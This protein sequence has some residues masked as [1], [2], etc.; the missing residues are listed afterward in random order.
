V[1]A[2]AAATVA[3]KWLL[4]PPVAPRIANYRPLTGGSHGR[5]NGLATDGE[6]AYFPTAGSLETRQ[7]AMAGGSSAPLALPFSGGY[8]VDASRARSSLLMVGFEEESAIDGPLWSVPVPAGGARKLGIEARWAAWRPDGER[9]A[10]VRSEAPSLLGVARGDGSEVTTLFESRDDLRWVRWSPDG[11]R[12]R[13]GL[14]EAGTARNWIMEIPAAGGTPRRLFPGLS[15]DWTPDGRTFLFSNGGA[16]A[17]WGWAPGAGAEGRVNLFAA[18]DPPRWQVWRKPRIEQLTTGPLHLSWPTFGKGVRRVIAWGSNWRGQLMRFDARSSRFEPL[19][20]GLQGGFLDY[21]RD[22]LWIAWVDVRD[23]TL[24][25]SRADGSEALQLTTPP[26]AVGLVRWSPDGS[27]LAFVAKPPES[28]PR[29]YVLP[30]DGGRP[31]VLSEPE[32]G[33]VWDP[34]WMPDGNRIIWG[35]IGGGGIRMYDRGTRKVSVLPGTDDLWFP[36][37]SPQGLLLATHAFGGSLGSFRIYDPGTGK[38]EDLGLS[39]VLGYP[40]F[41]RDGQSVIGS[42]L[43]ATPGIF[44]FSLRERRLEKVADLGTLRLTSP[45]FSPNWITLGPDDAPIVL[46]DTSTHELYALELEWP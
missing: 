33:Q 8:V 10:F 44:A 31:E 14:E 25:R 39:G 16:S 12:L 40:S 5:F 11:K 3:A 9:L 27:Q 2:G 19:L 38:A 45:L 35:R 32:E 29:V 4:A 28:P 24:W 17:G 15:G 26:L 30:S 7:V 43:T 6:R 22:G 42:S 41:T 23:L 21:S 34:C 13:F 20:G 1:A 37:C 46:N 18:V 36:K